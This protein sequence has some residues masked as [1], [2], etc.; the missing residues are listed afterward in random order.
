MPTSFLEIVELENG[1][2]VLQS[3][4]DS[5]SAPMVRIAF[6]EEAKSYM[7]GREVDVARV[8][9]HAGLQAVSQVLEQTQDEHDDPQ[10]DAE[11]VLH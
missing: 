6:S 9:I 5:G 3:E 11:R 10:D 2:V 8:M 7:Q 1:D 4:D